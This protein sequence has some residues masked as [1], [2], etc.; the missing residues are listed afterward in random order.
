MEMTLVHLSSQRSTLAHMSTA[1]EI[2]ETQLENRFANLLRLEAEKHLQLLHLSFLFLVFQVRCC[3]TG[4]LSSQQASCVMA[5]HLASPLFPPPGGSRRLFFCGFPF[6]WVLH[7]EFYLM[8]GVA[9]HGS[10]S[11]SRE[12]SLDECGRPCL[13][14]SALWLRC[15]QSSPVQETQSA[16]DLDLTCDWLAN[17]C[18][19]FDD[20]RSSL[21]LDVP[22]GEQQLR[23][24]PASIHSRWRQDALQTQPQILQR[25]TRCDGRGPFLSEGLRRITWKTRGLVGSVLQTKEKRI[26]TQVSQK[27]LGQQQHYVSRKCMERTSFFTLSRCWLRELGSLIPT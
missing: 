3:A 13:L 16:R 1:T 21:P 26:Q 10:S 2:E 5:A 19:R 18:G 27:T 17:L 7:F 15:N 14:C 20:S 11:C 8:C 12:D 25:T 4:S 9:M 23:E 6:Q 24:L 22:S